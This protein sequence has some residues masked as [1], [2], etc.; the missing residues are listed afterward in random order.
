MK[1]ALATPLYS[2][3]SGGPATYA[4]LLCNH[5]PALGD[6]VTLVKFSEVRHLPKVIRHIAYFSKV[7]NAARD[8]DVILALD[9]V[10]V[11]LPAYVAARI[12]RKPFVVKVVGDFAWE[13]GRQRFGVAEPLDAFVRNMHV[14]FPVAFL[15]TIQV[16]VARGAQQIIVPSNYLKGIITA[17]GIAPSKITVIYNSIELPDISSTTK[18]N[19][20]QIVSVGRLVPWKGMSELIDALEKVQQHI[21][22]ASLVIVGDGP[23]R[24]ELEKKSGRDVS[25]TGALSHE[26]TLRTMQSAEVFALNSSYEGLSHTVIEALMLGS[27]IVVSDAGGNPELIENGVNGVVV[28]VGNTDVLSNALSDMLNNVEQRVQLSVSAKKSSS[29]FKVTTMISDT[30]ALLLSVLKTN[31][32]RPLE[33]TLET[34]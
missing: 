28:P 14:P 10:S 1:I 24:A 20:G 4:K 22:A 7:L 31:Q 32:D 3:D 6:Q 33:T 25:F 21:P 2:P 16:F 8:A 18:K 12:L 23:Q 17:W 11:G 30:H 9:P 27:A 29:R 19:V 13:Q 15:R 34:I 26:E 5:L